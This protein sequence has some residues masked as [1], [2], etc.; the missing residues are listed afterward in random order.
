[1]VKTA[2]A[3]QKGVDNQKA[4]DSKKRTARTGQ[5]NTIARRTQQ[6]QGK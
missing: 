3:G 1:L 6:E 2:I 4:E 5:L